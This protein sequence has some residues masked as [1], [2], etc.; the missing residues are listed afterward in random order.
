M[1]LIT[2]LITAI[3]FLFLLKLRWPNKEKSLCNTISSNKSHTTTFSIEL[4]TIKCS[5][6]Y[7]PGYDFLG[8]ER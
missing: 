8:E 3:C 2:I 4:Y 7:I 6:I 5:L 1:H